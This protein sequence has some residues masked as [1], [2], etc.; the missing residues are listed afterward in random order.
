MFRRFTQRARNAVLYAQEEARQLNHPAI[1]TEHILLGLLKEGEG[2]GARALLSMGVD[3][4]RVRSEVTRVIGQG[5]A[6]AEAPD[7]DLP[8]P[9]Y[10]ICPSSIN[11]DK[12]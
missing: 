6:E 8:V 3:L 4:D 10:T 7:G 11:K 12:L 1:G 9:T 2:V 5:T